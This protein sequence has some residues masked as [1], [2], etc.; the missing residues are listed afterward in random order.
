MHDLTSTAGIVAIGAGAVA[1]VSF[2]FCIVLAFRLRRVRKDQRAVLGD[3][4]Q[5]LVAHAAAL[6]SQFEALSDY[7]AG[8]RRAAR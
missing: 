1:V 2:L 4:H 5:D 7:V 8:R 3:G 6:Q